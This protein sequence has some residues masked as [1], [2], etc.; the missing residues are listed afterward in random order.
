MLL[1]RLHLQKHNLEYCDVLR[2]CRHTVRITTS[3]IYNLTLQS[4]LPLCHIY[5]A[6]THT[7]IFHRALPVSAYNRKTLITNC[8]YKNSLQNCFYKLSVQTKLFYV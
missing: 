4:V 5:T 2:H 8:F 6:Y 7:P 1:I 3:F